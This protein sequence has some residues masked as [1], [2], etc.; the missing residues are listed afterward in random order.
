VG[1]EHD[2]RV[3]LGVE[4][5]LE[6]LAREPG[7][8]AARALQRDIGV[9]RTSTSGKRDSTATSTEAAK[10]SLTEDRRRV[11]V[12][13][14]LRQRVEAGAGLDLLRITT[15]ACMPTIASA[16]VSALYSNWLRVGASS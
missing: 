5:D 12:A 7:L 8:A 13:E 4:V 16:M 10:P 6:E 3:A 2:Q 1:G 15:S 14:A 9:P 11:G